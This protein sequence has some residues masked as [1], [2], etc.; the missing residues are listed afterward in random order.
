MNADDLNTVARTILG[1]ARG[2][3]WLGK[4]A[5]AWCIRN[6]VDADLGNDDK[7]DWWGE[8]Y[9][10]VCR[11]KWQFSCWLDSDP[12]SKFIA[13]ADPATNDMLRDCYAAAALVM[14]GAVP[15]PTNGA[16]HYFNP[17]AANPDW[18]KGRAPVAKIGRHSF[19]RLR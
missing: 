4:I 19:Y 10:G 6:R 2:E 8:G 17:A 9:V 7:P 5:V 13:T 16:D 12:N 3:P 1:E 14:T 15:D 11:K 18:A